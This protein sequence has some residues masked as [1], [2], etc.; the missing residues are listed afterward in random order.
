MPNRQYGGDYRPDFERSASKFVRLPAR[1]GYWTAARKAHV[2]DAV[3]NGLLSLEEACERYA[4]TVEE[5]MS[6]RQGLENHGLPGLQVSNLQKDP[7]LNTPVPRTDAVTIGD[8]IAAGRA[9]EIG[10][11]N[12]NR[13]GYYDAATLGLPEWLP[14]PEVAK[15]LRCQACGFRNNA[16]SEKVWAR[17][18]AR[19]SPSSAPRRE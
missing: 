15:R 13:H 4:M 19:P 1:G 18:D 17:P 7:G 11:L 6:W 12:C 3:R 9:I 10:C 8:L 2:V 14:V 16:N 5:F